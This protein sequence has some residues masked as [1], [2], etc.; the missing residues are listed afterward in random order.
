[1]TSSFVARFAL[2]VILAA[3]LPG[4]GKADE[5]A[6][7]PAAVPADRQILVMIKMAPA[8]YRPNSAYGGS[9]GDGAAMAS[10]RRL[11]R[12]IARRNGLELIDGWPMPLLSVDC[13]VMRVPE[14]QSVDGL[15]ARLSSE[16]NVAW[17]QPMQTFQAM[18]GAPV[19]N[20]PL[21]RVEPAAITW[22]LAELYRVA[23]G[24]GV[25]I[26][27][28][29]SKVDD[30]HPDLAGQIVAEQ[31]FVTDQSQ[32]A[33]G[34]GTGVAGVIAARLDNGIGIAGIAPNARIMALR[35]CW[36][37]STTPST[38]CSSLTLARALQYAIDHN[39][40]I[41]NLSLSGPSDPL[42]Q[43]LIELALIKKTT[44]VTAFDVRRP[45]GGFPASLPGV[46]AVSD[47]RLQKLPPTVYGAPG[48]DVPTTQPGGKWTLVSGTSFAVAHVS[49]LM[50]LIRER[51]LARRAAL[52]RLP[53]GQIDACASL[54]VTT[55]GCN[56]LCAIDRV[57]ARAQSR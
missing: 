4:G 18:S 17:S 31:D 13:F 50:A 51:Q 10:R 46:V 15:V 29:D 48:S 52:V 36:Q 12:D 43:K 5:P 30:A 32:S 38:L 39:A 16:P 37:A 9:Y 19:P 3:C 2:A 47:E 45:Q 7:V 24:K 53:N 22:N 40:K 49:G 11:A 25:S 6:E 27:V 57:V 21:F 1:M 42:L 54:L 14:G 56:C 35:A 55:A 8:H 23:T 44:I 34:H 28:V 26:A 41:I 33:E 20:D